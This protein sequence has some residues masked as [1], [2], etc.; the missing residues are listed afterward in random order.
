MFD[1]YG[2]PLALVFEEFFKD[3]RKPE[4][5]R[6]ERD[7]TAD[8]ET[9]KE[10][11]GDQISSLASRSAAIFMDSFRYIVPRGDYYKKLKAEKL[12][13]ERVS[14]APLRRRMIRLLVLIPEKKSLHLAQKALDARDI[15]RV[16]A[17]FAEI[18]VSPVTIS[19]RHNIK[20]L[21][22]LY[23]LLE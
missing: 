13:V 2:L 21:E 16:M 12:I 1:T 15:K 19:K 6:D 23:G 9:E 3:E 11:I 14:E 7:E 22:S 4:R 5:E 18:G 17:E 8:G 10:S 20:K